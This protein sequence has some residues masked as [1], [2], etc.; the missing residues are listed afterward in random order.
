MT[1]TLDLV[2]FEGP[3]TAEWIWGKTGT[4]K[5]RTAREENPGFFR[6]HCNKWWDGYEG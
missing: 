4:G 3:K 5:T 1:K 6:K 2:C